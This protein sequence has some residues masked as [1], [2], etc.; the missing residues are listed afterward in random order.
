MDSKCFEKQLAEIQKCYDAERRRLNEEIKGLR[1]TLE[2]TPDV[3]AAFLEERDALRT[4]NIELRGHVKTLCTQ[5]G[6]ERD[7]HDKYSKRVLQAASVVSVVFV[8]ETTLLSEAIAEGIGSLFG[9]TTAEAASV[10]ARAATEAVKLVREASKMRKEI[11]E[12]IER[13]TPRNQESGVCAKVGNRVAGKILE[14][15]VEKLEDKVIEAGI[16]AAVGAVQH[17]REENRQRCVK[18]ADVDS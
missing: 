4:Q 16:D 15:V 17:S 3:N 6:D 14:K 11:L 1:C 8:V 12:E 13:K 9:L 2:H 7:R 5:I 18:Y 10:E